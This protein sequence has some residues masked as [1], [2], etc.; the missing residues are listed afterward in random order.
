M[1]TTKSLPFDIPFTINKKLSCKYLPFLFLPTSSRSNSQCE[2]F[3]VLEI[4]GMAREDVKY[5]NNIFLLLV[6]TLIYVGRR[7]ERSVFQH[8]S[9]SRA[10][11]PKKRSCDVWK[12]SIN[13]CEYISGSEIDNL[14][15][16]FTW[17]VQKLSLMQFVASI[18]EP[19]SDS[20]IWKNFRLKLRNAH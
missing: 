11:P 17:S 13:C 20:K 1:M 4:E 8:F 14:C 3:C 5:I 12:T 15:S 18:S 19:S 7:N 2:T 9:S 16:R 10:R 6:A